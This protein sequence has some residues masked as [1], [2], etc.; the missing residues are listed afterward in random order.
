MANIAKKPDDI[1]SLILSD[2]AKKQ[3]A[4][5][6]PRHLT[7]E[8]FTRIALT[9]INRT[10][11]LMQCAKESLLTCLLDL[12][13]LGLEPDNRKAHLI[14]YE[15]RKLG[16]TIC[17][18]IIDYKGLVELARRSG[19]ISDIHADVVCENDHF[20]YSFGTDGRLV[21]KPAIKDRG[22][23]IAAYS[24]V[25]LKDGSSSY[26][27]MNKEEVEAIRERSKAGAT[28]PWV[29]DWKEMA[30]KTVFRRHSKWLP[31]SPEFQEAIDKD[32]DVPVDIIPKG[33]PVVAM[34]EA[35]PEAYSEPEPA[36]N[37][38]LEP[39]SIAKGRPNAIALEIAKSFKDCADLMTLEACL[40]ENQEN[41]DKLSKL[42]AQWVMA[43]YE[44]QAERI[45]GTNG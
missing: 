39:E 32:Y 9:A 40:A 8:R 1:R 16:R 35:L 41:I 31:V 14:P 10:P 43:E 22:N 23:V 15:N 18:L 29:T 4:Q 13:Q 2:S 34:P 42:D 17:T 24:F 25:K 3:F 45:E 37:G 6:L 21:H 5:A 20:E 19:E 28:G 36:Q 30:K 44:S 33:K 26:E 11:K 7:P 27:V 38:T 12:S